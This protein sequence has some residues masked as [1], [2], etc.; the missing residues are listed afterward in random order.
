MEKKSNNTY[1]V[2][3]KRTGCRAS[4]MEVDGKAGNG[5]TEVEIRVAP[6][7]EQSKATIACSLSF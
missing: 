1:S 3:W 4:R 5:V 6:K 7:T 2:E